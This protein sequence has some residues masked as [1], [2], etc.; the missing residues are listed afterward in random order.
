MA[1]DSA[2]IGRA[3]QSW[4]RQREFSEQIDRKHPAESE[5]TL[6]THLLRQFSKGQL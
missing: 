3:Q 4:T 6:P 2:Q 5:V 1:N